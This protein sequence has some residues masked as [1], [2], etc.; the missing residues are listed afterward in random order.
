M[1]NVFG[2]IRVSTTEQDNGVSPEEQ[3][4]AIVRYA[5]KHELNII[6]WFQE[7]KTAAK[8]GRPLFNKMMKLVREG[9]SIGVIIHKVDRSARNLRDWASIGD[10]IDKGFEFHFANESLDMKQRG[11]RLAADIQAVI[12]SDFIRNLREE[13]LKGLY[14]RLK[15]GIY[16]F[17][18]PIGYLN[19]GKGNV[20]IIDKIMG[21]LVRKAFEQYATGNYT[22]EMLV[23][24]MQKLGLRN[25]K[26][27]SIKLTGLALI[28]HNPFYTGI[29]K[30]KGKT[31]QGKHEPLVS[32]KLFL[33]VQNIL[34]GKTN[35]RSIKHEF[36]F[37]K[38]I[39]CG[40]CNYSLI[41]EK[42]K[43]NVYYRCQTKECQTKTI[44]EDSIE[45][46]VV[47][48]FED[49]HLQPLEDKVLN[50]LLEEVQM[51][52]STTEKNFED[53]FKLQQNKILQKIDRLTDA[54]F[55]G[56]IDKTQLETKKEHF[57]IE[58]Q[59]LKK[60]EGQ[61]DKQREAIF[62]KA[63]NFLEQIKSVEKSYQ[64][65]IKEEK[66]KIIKTITSNL[67]IEGRKLM[68]TMKSPFNE[69]VTD[70]NFLSCVLERNTPRKC[71]AQIATVA[72]NGH[73]QNS[74]TNH[75]HL[76]E[77]IESKNSSRIVEDN[78]ELRDKMKELLDEILRYF[79]LNDDDYQDN[80]EFE[81]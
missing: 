1:K 43:G 65:G 68:I 13:T 34:Q 59:G 51:N 21:P 58:L 18:A 66:R 37:R 63:K 16:P 53:S 77:L 2:Y 33:K 74:S 40:D 48:S 26:G 64:T 79:E 72:I 55:E 7:T 20:K 46:A 9:K 14:G 60:K 11:G 38:L 61:F 36:L 81:V 78:Q 54:Y 70:S 31:F 44:R 4:D 6:Q 49:I 8:Q 35:T 45:K 56:I 69:L 24:E 17:G 76:P 15:Q 50:E 10:L 30:I 42:Q 57:M 62:R 28:L 5:E 27:N 23:E 71:T 41:G 3:K 32:P 52:W 47:L 67:T 19:T 29:M 39:K 73:N 22:L 25:S 12:A 75:H 80:K